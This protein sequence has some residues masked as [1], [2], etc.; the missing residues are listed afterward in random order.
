MDVAP[1]DRGPIRH[2]LYRRLRASVCGA[3]DFITFALLPQMVLAVVFVAWSSI[4]RD[5][6]TVVLPRLLVLGYLF[7]VTL[8]VRRSLSVVSLR[9]VLLHL[10]A[11]TVLCALSALLLADNFAAQAVLPL[12]A[13]FLAIVGLPLR[14]VGS[15]LVGL[16][17]SSLLILSG[18]LFYIRADTGF[19]AL[20]RFA[21]LAWGGAQIA[22]VLRALVRRPT[23]TV[24]VESGPDLRDAP[25][26]ETSRVPL[27]DQELLRFAN[28]AVL[29]AWRPYLI[30]PTFA[31]M[32]LGALVSVLH[33][34]LWQR[35]ASALLP[36]LLLQIV[37]VLSLRR[38]KVVGQLQAGVAV[39]LA[40]VLAQW[41]LVTLGT[42]VLSVDLGV[43]VGVLTFA[44]C[45]LPLAGRAATVVTGMALLCS[46]LVAMQ[47]HGVLIALSIAGC[48]LGGAVVRLELR[49]LLGVHAVLVLQR[50]IGESVPSTTSLVQLLAWQLRLRAGSSSALVLHADAA[51]EIVDDMQSRAS[52]VDRIYVRGLMQR[53][54]EAGGEQV[55]L[56]PQLGEQ[57]T[58]PLLS[59]FGELPK[60]L[61]ALRL[62]VPAHGRD[63]LAFVVVPVGRMMTA[64][65][66]ALLLADTLTI[67]A[68]PQQLFRAA[69]SGLYS[70]E[71]L[72]SSRQVASVRDEELS[73][74]VHGVNNTAQEVAVLC[75][76]ARRDGEVRAV[77]EALALVERAV[78]VL[79]FRASDVKLRRE[80]LTFSATRRREQVAIEALVEDL[81][82]FAAH[83]AQ[84]RG[85]DLAFA[86]SVPA[87]LQVVTASA[88]LLGT[89]LR[90][91]VEESTQ[92]ALSGSQAQFQLS[93]IEGRVRITFEVVLRPGPP[94]DAPREELRAAIA[95]FLSQ[96]GAHL[97]EKEGGGWSLE[98]PVAT[99]QRRDTGAE[100]DGWALLVDDHPHMT[101]FY[102]RVAEALAIRYVTA[103]S[104]T[105]AREVVLREGPPRIVVT[106]VRLGEES[107]V[108]LVRWLRQEHEMTIPIIVVSGE[109]GLEL[110][111]TYRELQVAFLAKPVGR[112]RLFDAMVELLKGKEGAT[113]QHKERVP[114]GGGR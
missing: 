54:H 49:R 98:L 47:G 71:L 36:L 14:A 90:C 7:A 65:E 37:T 48:V 10:S 113:P 60:Q 13:F 61:M 70:S 86:S 93:Q 96:H 52:E 67:S 57:Y 17:A 11:L 46:V 99:T 91:L 27:L 95:R 9:V 63:D 41:S 78:R 20:D 103:A 16:S 66:R 2:A 25:H 3:R 58:L 104:V 23:V 44:S 69:R 77:R 4:L 34:E 106:D 35:H 101:D 102:A 81:T 39:G 19:T 111:A 56:V 31:A 32:A 45:A 112:R 40:S 89:T 88:D 76:D 6:L 75:E 62:S 107:G 100:H 94:G 97:E 26:S 114:N 108:D 21:W 38:V 55:V 92:R 24:S 72:L 29:A 105:E 22:L 82:A 85:L 5:S 43:L 83:R 1:T 53:I 50:R 8:L 73:E 110:E 12:A 84:W 18:A 30:P 42:S 33:L 15:A 28:R 74:V 80:L 68:Y 109:S 64:R 87:G 79:A 59:W 51:A